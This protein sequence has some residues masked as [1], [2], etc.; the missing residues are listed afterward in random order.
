MHAN[1]FDREH[2]DKFSCSFIHCWQLP[3]QTLPVYH[4]PSCTL[5]GEAEQLEGTINA[6]RLLQVFEGFRQRLK[7]KRA[8][9]TGASEQHCLRSVRSVKPSYHC[10]LQL[11]RKSGRISKIEIHLISVFLTPRF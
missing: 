9:R 10:Y 11:I 7:T 5:S 2:K 3:L 6:R 4:Q 8:R 1:T